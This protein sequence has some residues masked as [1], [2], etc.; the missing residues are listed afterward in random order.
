MRLPYSSCAATASGLD[1]VSPVTKL[2]GFLRFTVLGAL[3][4]ILMGGGCVSDLPTLKNGVCT[5]SPS[6]ACG[7][8][9]LT[10][11]GSLDVNLTGYSCT[12]TAR[13]DDNPNY[14]P[15]IPRGIVCADRGAGANGEQTYCCTEQITSC[16]SDPTI[17]CESGTRGYQ[18]RGASRPDVFNPT[19]SCLQGVREHEY[20]N[21]CCNGLTSCV[22]DSRVKCES[23]MDGFQCPEGSRPDVFDGTVT[24]Q[25]GFGDPDGKHIDYCCN[26]RP[27]PT[28]AESSAECDARLTSF[29]CAPGALPRGS[30]L[31][32]KESHADNYF[33]V[34]P[35]GKLAPNGV[36]M[37]YC[38]YQAAPLPEGAS[39]LQ[40]TNVP[41]CAIGRFGFACTGVDTPDQNYPPMHCPD[42][43]FPGKSMEGYS[44]T[45]YCCDYE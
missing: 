13:P 45:L 17:S 6:I 2:S 41:G 3:P 18:C 20:I 27:P 43:G 35:T 21:Y 39:C 10:A 26:G 4:L 11:D 40:H 44:A 22:A 37:N 42:P 28:C 38:C 34:C 16:V 9:N 24:C 5:A 29:Q 25:Q 1:L 36:Y 12:G 7:V 31:L 23:G 15:D 33:F 30:D 8:K 14:A 32:A 19:I